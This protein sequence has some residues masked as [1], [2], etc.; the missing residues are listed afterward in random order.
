MTISVMALLAALCGALATVGLVLA[1]AGSVGWTPSTGSRRRTRGERRLRAVLGTDRSGARTAWWAAR[2]TRLLAA[3][4]AGAGVWLATSW[5]LGG[6]LA[7]CAVGGLQWMLNPGQ[8]HAHQIARLE[9]LEE[10]VRRM[11]DIHTVGISLEQAVVSSIR[12]VPGPIAVPVQQMVARLGAGWKPADAYRAFADDLND[13]TSDMVVALMLLHVTDRGAGL[14]RALR[15]LSAAVAEEVLMRRKVEAD[16]AK[17]KANARWVTIFCLGV[18]GLSMFSG[19]YVQPYSTPLGVGVL[20]ALAL[21]FVGLL[22]WMRRM[23][24]MRPTAR[25]LSPLDRTGTATLE[26]SR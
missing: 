17:P 4:A 19:S 11:S 25:F 7:A 20:V 15:E 24:T 13:S 2:R 12:T 23:A 10:W 14:G 8:E 26:D 5:L 16:R 9:A 6:L 22:V 18:F 21:G 1:V 3:C